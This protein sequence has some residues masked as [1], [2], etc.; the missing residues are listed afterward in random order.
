[1]AANG[2]KNPTDFF[3]SWVLIRWKNFM[4]STRAPVFSL[5]ENLTYSIESEIFVLK[6][7]I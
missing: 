7:K 5:S 6:T 1:L 3:I 4:L 2:L